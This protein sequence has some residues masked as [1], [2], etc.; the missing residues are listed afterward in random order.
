VAG[1]TVVGALRG[2][3]ALWARPSLVRA[4]VLGATC[5]MAALARAELISL[6]PL[7]ALPVALTAGARRTALSGMVLAASALVVGPWVLFN[8]SRFEASTLISTSDG[9]VL[10]G[11]NCEGVYS[12]A[13]I[14]LGFPHPPCLDSPPPPGDQ[15][16][17]SEIYRRRALRYALDHLERVP[18]VVAARIGRTWSLYR[19]SDM[20]PIGENEGRERWVTALGLVAYYPTLLA[21]LAGA[22]LLWRA[23]RRRE[24]WVLVVA[25]LSVTLG[26]AIS[27]GST[28]YRAAAEPSLAILAAVSIAACPPRKWASSWPRSAPSG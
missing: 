6:L 1:L 18:V 20:I 21:A 2:A 16:Q 13:G 14:G 17:V 9:I 24:L 3:L 26:T 23:R 25:A 19:P 28:R 4:A 22:G 15:S 27:S 8:L 10:A 7:L 12:G 11:S 5:G